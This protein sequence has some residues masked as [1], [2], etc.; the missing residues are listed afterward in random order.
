M[1]IVLRIGGSITASPI[2]LELISRYV[3]LLLELVR[4]GNKVVAVVGG[5][6]LAREYI[7]YG[8]ELGL[9]EEAQDWLAIEVSRL[10]ARLINLKLD[11]CGKGEVETSV[12]EVLE[13]FEERSVVVVG[14][15]SPG[16][17]T[18][19]VAALIAREARADILVKATDQDGIYTNDPRE[20]PEAKKLDA[21]TFT[22]LQSLFKK[23]KHS[24]GIH[25][26]LDPVAVR[27]LRE[28]KVR[29]IVVNGFDPENVKRAIQGERIGTRIME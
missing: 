14:G 2:N 19:S 29:T 7:Q 3:N 28:A 21:I 13:S 25:Q 18:D 11:G 5:G 16:M 24:A 10:H 6:S 15:L 9:E 17:T 8:R 26:I 22:D 23:S 1:I 27:I 12:A 4:E 20:Y